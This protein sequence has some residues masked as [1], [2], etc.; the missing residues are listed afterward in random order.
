MGDKIIKSRQ[1]N[2][3]LLRII[4]TIAVVLIHVNAIV[5]DSNNIIISW[6]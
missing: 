6:I 3:D 4:S 2:F 1:S 5:A